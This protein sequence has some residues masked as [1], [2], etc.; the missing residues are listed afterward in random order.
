M[1]IF[2][3][4]KTRKECL[5]ACIMVSE[6]YIPIVLKWV[7]KGCIWGNNHKQI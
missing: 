5:L 6:K 7:L 2:Q 1:F 3:I 4:S